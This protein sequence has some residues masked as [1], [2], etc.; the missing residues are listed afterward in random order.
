MMHMVDKDKAKS[1]K[2]ANS[3]KKFKANAMRRFL[4]GSHNASTHVAVPA[5]LYLHHLM[6]PSSGYKHCITSW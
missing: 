3:K 5:I 1:K 6:V 2:F 4:W